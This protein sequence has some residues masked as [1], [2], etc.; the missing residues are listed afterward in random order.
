MCTG[1]TS[2]FLHSD[3]NLEV[4]RKELIMDVAGGAIAGAVILRILEGI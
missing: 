4:L 3:G 2:A 1:P